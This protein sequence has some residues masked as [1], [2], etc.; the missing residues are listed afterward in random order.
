MKVKDERYNFTFT[1]TQ[2]DDIDKRRYS[3]MSV[4]LLFNLFLQKQR[5][6]KE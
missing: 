6:N 1:R 3:F 2:R 4:F 5:V